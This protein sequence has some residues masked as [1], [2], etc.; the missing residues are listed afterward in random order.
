MC[1]IILGGISK[2]EML[3]LSDINSVSKPVNG[4]VA[5]STSAFTFLDFL[6]STAYLQEFRK[7]DAKHGDYYEQKLV[8]STKS[9][10][11]DQLVFDISLKNKLIYFIVHDQ[12]NK[13]FFIPKMRSTRNYNTDKL[14]GKNGYDYEFTAKSIKPM[15]LC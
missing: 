6:K 11:N 5:I 1:G 3:L 14:K 2:I 10:S 7:N 15:Y 4:Q 13:K 8:F 12:N 9:N